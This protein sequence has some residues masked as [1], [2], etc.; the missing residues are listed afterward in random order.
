MSAVAPDETGK[1]PLISTQQM[2]ELFT[3]NG[4]AIFP[5]RHKHNYVAQLIDWAKSLAYVQY[6]E[7]PLHNLIDSYFKEVKLSSALKN[8]LVLSGNANTYKPYLFSSYDEILKECT[9][10]QAGKATSAAPSYFPAFSFIPP[11]SKEP[12]NLVDGGL[13]QNNPSVLAYEETLDIMADVPQQNIITLSLGTG[14]FPK[15]DIPQQTGKLLAAEPVIDFMMHR[16]SEDTH[17]RMK[18]TLKRNNY[19]RINPQFTHTLKLDSTG[20]DVCVLFKEVAES[21]Y[22]DIET[23][24]VDG[25]LRRILE[26]SKL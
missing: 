17:L 22:E 1:K 2:I 8:V 18:N 25:P 19:L 13:W 15:N 6:S 5:Q 23:F 11:Q 9:M 10:S 7:K 26:Q 14:I 16:S 24:V 4:E 20:S 3:K 12:V 21:K